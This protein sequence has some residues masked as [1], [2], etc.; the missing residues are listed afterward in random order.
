M[1]VLNVSLIAAVLLIGVARGFF[2]FNIVSHF[3]LLSEQAPAQRGQVMTLGAAVSLVGA[4]VAGFTGPW[5]LVNYG[6]PAL[7]WS[8]AAVVTISLLTVYF[9]V[10]ERPET[11]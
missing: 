2:E 9:L 4:T 5:L 6:V 7:A 11:S 3:P 10:Q 8:S 1:P